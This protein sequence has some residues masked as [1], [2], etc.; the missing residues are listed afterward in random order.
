M[1]GAFKAIVQGMVRGVRA[2][3]AQLDAAASVVQDKALLTE[4]HAS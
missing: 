1:H 3:V 4:A 2:F